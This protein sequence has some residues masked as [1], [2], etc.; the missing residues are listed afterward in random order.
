M[1]RLQVGDECYV[2]DYET[3][4]IY[5]CRFGMRDGVKNT[6]WC[7][8]ESEVRLVGGAILVS[9]SLAKKYKNRLVYPFPCVKKL[10]Q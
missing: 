4:N 9:L 5:R 1:N 7:D 3:D 2:R 6:K 10:A 8:L